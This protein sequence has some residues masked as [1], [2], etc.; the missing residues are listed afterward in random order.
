MAEGVARPQPGEH[1]AT[2]GLGEGAVAT[3]SG[4]EGGAGAAWGATGLANSICS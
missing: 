1:T 4:E 3:R 2:V